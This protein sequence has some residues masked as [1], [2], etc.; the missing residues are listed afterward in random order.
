MCP[1]TTDSSL[2]EY[3]HKV[4]TATEETLKE[5]ETLNSVDPSEYISALRRNLA[6]GQ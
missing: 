4:S 1:S 6:Q 5:T 2:G 3:T